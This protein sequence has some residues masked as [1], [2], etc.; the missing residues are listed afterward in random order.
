MPHA[1]SV[2]RCSVSVVSQNHARN[3]C[4]GLVFWF[5]FLAKCDYVLSVVEIN[6]QISSLVVYVQ[7]FSSVRV[8]Y[9]LMLFYCRLTLEPDI[10]TVSSSSILSH[11]AQYK[12]RFLLEQYLSGTVFPKPASARIPSPHSMRSSV[13][14][15]EQ[16]AHAHR[17]DTRKWSDDY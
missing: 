13:T 6:E 11:T 14:H 15:P 16:C 1:M 3:S 5:L 8:L 4:V 2:Y 12:H 17:R 7:C 9:K 10:T